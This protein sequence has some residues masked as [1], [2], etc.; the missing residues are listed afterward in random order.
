[1]E[2]RGHRHN[3]SATIQ[4]QTLLQ[5][6]DQT[7]SYLEERANTMQS[8]E[9]TIVELGTIFTQLTTLVHQQ[10]EM[11]TRID[12][13]VSDTMMN[14]EAAHQSLLQYLQSVTSNRWLVIKVFGILFVFF[15]V[16]VLFAS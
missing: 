13:N 16:F 9:S 1:M 8:I 6:E 12:A 11:I 2:V 15:I 5:F 14:V 10:E 4:T 3:N 7:N